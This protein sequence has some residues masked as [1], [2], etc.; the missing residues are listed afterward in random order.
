MKIIL[1][2]FLL[3]GIAFADKEY[4][5]QFLSSDLQGKDLLIKEAQKIKNIPKVR[6][7]QR[8]DFYVLR[9]GVFISYGNA[10]KYLTNIKKEYKEAFVRTC[11]FNRDNVIY[12]KD[13]ASTLKSVELQDDNLHKTSS[14]EK[15]YE[16][17]KEKYTST[18][19]L[20]ANSSTSQENFDNFWEEVLYYLEQNISTN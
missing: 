14:D 11:E 6:V 1:T 20:K 10:L 12:I 18:K 5:I 17:Q 9:G 7:E 3:F 15:V 4:C 13:S 19:K 2:I 16:K 8:G